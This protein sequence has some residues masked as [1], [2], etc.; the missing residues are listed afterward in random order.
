MLTRQSGAIGTRGD[1]CLFFFWVSAKEALHLVGLE[2]AM[3][4]GTQ[5]HGA[6]GPELTCGAVSILWLLH[7]LLLVQKATLGSKPDSPM[8]PSMN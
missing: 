6:R 7:P 4:D 3:T 1:Q 2:A 8:M 5:Q